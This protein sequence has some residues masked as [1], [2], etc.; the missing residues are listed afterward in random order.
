M[1]D[2]ILETSLFYC[3]SVSDY[4]SLEL[5]QFIPRH[6]EDNLKKYLVKFSRIHESDGMFRTYIVADQRTD[7]MVGWFSLQSATLPYQKKDSQFHIPAIELTNFAVN[8]RYY[9]E[10]S[11]KEKTSS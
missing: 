1:A 4:N 9:K 3:T 2:K 5:K 11:R 8:E 10:I 7:A 6:E